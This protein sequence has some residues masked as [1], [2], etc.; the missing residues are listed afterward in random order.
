M[1]S[2]TLDIHT[3]VNQGYERLQLIMRQRR[4]VQSHLN[5]KRCSGGDLRERHCSDNGDSARLAV[6]DTDEASNMENS[7]LGLLLSSSISDLY[8][9][10][11]FNLHHMCRA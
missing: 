8:P 6:C 3:L 7:S 11:F 4:G 2:T 10:P 5:D 9:Y 1:Q